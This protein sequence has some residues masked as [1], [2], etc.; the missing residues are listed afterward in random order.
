VHLNVATFISDDEPR[1]GAGAFDGYGCG[2]GFPPPPRHL[3]RIKTTGITKNTAAK[4]RMVF[5]QRDGGGSPRPHDVKSVAEGDWTS[6]S[7]NS[8]SKS[9]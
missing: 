8:L 2:Y 3:A 1:S 6:R 5:D 4:A 9:P 7:L